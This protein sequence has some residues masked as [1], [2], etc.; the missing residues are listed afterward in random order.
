V[1]IATEQNTIQGADVVITAAGAAGPVIAGAQNG[2]LTI[3]ERK[4]PYRELNDRTPLQL[5]GTTELSGRLM[6]VWRDISLIARLLGATSGGRGIKSGPLPRFTVTWT[7]DSPGKADHG[8]RMQMS[9]CSISVLT[10][11]TRDGENPIDAPITF[12]A[13][14]WAIL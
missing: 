12:D 5:R 10:L 14:N 8:R 2:E 11:T 4:V 9:G 13:E 6:G 1:A 3:T 7:V